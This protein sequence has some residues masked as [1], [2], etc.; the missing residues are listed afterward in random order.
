MIEIKATP[1]MLEENNLIYVCSPYKADTK[2]IL[3]R[4]IEYA[5]HLTRAALNNDFTPITP[6]LYLTQVTNEEDPEDRARGIAAGI[7]ILKHCKY[8]MVGEKY[9]IS[10]GMKEEIEVAKARGLIFVPLLRSEKTEGEDE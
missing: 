5:R 1:E 9:G 10:G 7:K 8:I 3:Q 6:H 2:E 4:N